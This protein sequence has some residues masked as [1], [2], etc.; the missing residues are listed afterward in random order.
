[1]IARPAPR[2]RPGPA[3]TAPAAAS[4]RP[5]R[6]SDLSAAGRRLADLVFA[7]HFGR[8][9]DLHV[10]A[11]EPVFD[12]PAPRV[13]RMVK[14]AGRPEPHPGPVPADHALRPE[15][16]DLL[17]QL[18]RLGDGVVTRLEVAHSIPLYVELADPAPAG[19]A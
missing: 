10:R 11:G 4:R 5:A 16:V 8:I 6:R 12:G 19:A 18:R 13:V 1:M 3:E 9:L 14:L 17:D 15:T 2:T 7:V